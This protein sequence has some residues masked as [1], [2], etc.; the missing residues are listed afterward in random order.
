MRSTTLPPDRDAR[1]RA[2]RWPPQLLMDGARQR[3]TVGVL[4]VVGARCRTTSKAGHFSFLGAAHHSSVARL[5]CRAAGGS[6]DE[7]RRGR[8]GQRRPRRH[9]RAGAR[10]WRDCGGSGGRSERWRQRV[11]M[12]LWPLGR[13]GLADGARVLIVAPNGTADHLHHA[14]RRCGTPRGRRTLQRGTR[15][16]PGGGRASSRPFTPERALSVGEIGRQRGRPAASSIVASS[17]LTLPIS[18]ST[19]PVECFSDLTSRNASD[20]AA[21]AQGRRS[22]STA[23]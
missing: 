15:C 11:K 21:L 20:P 1:S 9:C 18:D 2:P 8:R 13:R 6:P 4:E 23:H 16:A 3:P 10:P 14:R 17:A 7:W 12:P 5:G 19:V 22:T